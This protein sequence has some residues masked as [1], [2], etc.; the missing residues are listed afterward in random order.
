MCWFTYKK[1]ILWIYNVYIALCLIVNIKCIVCFSFCLKWWW[2]T[3]DANHTGD[4]QVGFSL[5]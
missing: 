5:T 3:C 4:S 2:V 1:Y